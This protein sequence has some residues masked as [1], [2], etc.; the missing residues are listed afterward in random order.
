MHSFRTILPVVAPVLLF[1][2]S[3]KQFLYNE[4]GSQYKGAEADG[5]S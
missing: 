1:V 2:K 3:F 4:I 5:A